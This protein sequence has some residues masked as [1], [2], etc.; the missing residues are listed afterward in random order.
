MNLKL[1]PQNIDAER[2]LLGS[3]LIDEEAMMQIAEFLKP[4]HFYDKNNGIIYEICIELYE[5]SRPIDLVTLTNALKKKKK[6]RSVGGAAYLSE[7]A[8][9]VPTAA[10]IVEY[11]NIIKEGSIRRKLINLGGRLSTLGFEEAK[12]LDEVMDMAEQNLFEVTGESVEKDFVHVSKLLEKTYERAEELNA[13]PDKLRG[14][15]T[16]YQ[17]IDNLLGGFQ[18]SDLVI[19][20]ARPSVGKTALAL[21]MTRHAVTEEKKKVGFFSLEMSNLQLMDRLL[22]MQVGIGLWDLRMGKLTDESFSRLADAM[23]VL[24]EAQLYIDDT[25]GLNIME[26]R[27]KARRLK[28]EHGVDM[29]FVDY[30]QLM[31]GRSKEGRVQEVSEISRFLKGMAR[32]LDVPVIALSQLSRAVEQRTDRKP[33]LS[34]LRDSGSIEQDADVVMF[35]HR[36][37][38]YNPET[39]RK[40]IT[41]IMVS[42]HR[43]GPTG[44]VELFFHKEQASFKSMNKRR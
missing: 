15:P 2:S 18:N 33:Q 44:I 10:N 13:N 42:K 41:D 7:L 35:I 12:E 20:A 3:I 17:D 37:E 9:L 39:D 26:M 8:S 31:E 38:Q 1:P 14:I 6:L 11:G 43:N 23:G 25:P 16:G 32:E 29:L 27:T 34:D 19:L 24:S 30:L 28:A 4:E 22:A 36:E 40:G 21:D 5:R